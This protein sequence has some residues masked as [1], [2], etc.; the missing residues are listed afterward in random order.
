MSDPLRPAS[1]PDLVT[2]AAD[3]LGALRATDRKSVV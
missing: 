3:L 1:A 2:E